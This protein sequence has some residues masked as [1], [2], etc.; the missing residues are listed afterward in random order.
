MSLRRGFKAE[1]DWYA[2]EMRRELKLNPHDPL[3]PWQ[4]ANHL[5]IEIVKLSGYRKEASEAVGYLMSKG[6]D[7]FSAVTVFPTRHGRKRVICTNDSHAKTRQAASVSH[8]LSH[9]LLGHPPTDMFEV[10]PIAEEEAHWMG[11]AL[12]V[13]VEAAMR[14]AFRK[15]S[16]DDAAE[17]YGVSA[18]LMRMRLNV[19]GALKRANR[20]LNRRSA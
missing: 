14:I 15:I 9:A 12:L 6:R 1:A 4:L 2:R 5:E 11:P 19:T 17:H 18:D 7:H 13:S 10:D 16:I 3:C 8:E 20:P